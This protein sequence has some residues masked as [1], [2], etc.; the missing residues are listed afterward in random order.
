MP[1]DVVMRR[2]RHQALAGRERES[3]LDGPAAVAVVRERGRP[4][5]GVIEKLDQRAIRQ[6]L[7]HR[8]RALLVR[9]DFSGLLF[10]L[11]HAGER[12]VPRR[13][14]LGAAICASGRV[15]PV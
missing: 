3:G 10:P 7:R 2:E 14:L 6:A 8:R 9:R 11:A 5:H 15:P 13:R 1:D 4:P 12:I